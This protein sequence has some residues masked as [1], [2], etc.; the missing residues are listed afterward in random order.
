MDRKNNRHTPKIPLIVGLTLLFT[1]VFCF[2][3]FE[4]D[5]IYD[6]DITGFD[7]VSNELKR[8]ISVEEVIR[9]VEQ[10][11][12]GEEEENA[13]VPGSITA[14]VGGPST[15]GTTQPPSSGGSQTTPT[16]PGNQQPSNPGS[17]QPSN[18]Q[19]TQPTQPQPQPNPPQPAPSPTPG[20]AED[21]I[22][23]GLYTRED[24][25]YLVA[26]A[27]EDR[28]YEGFYA[29]ACCVR[30]RCQQLGKTVKEV[31]TAP[32]QFTGYNTADI[33]NYSNKDVYNAAIEV[34]RGGKSTVKDYM[35][36]FGRS[37]GYDIWYEANKCG[38]NVP[39]V[40]GTG[41]C[42]NV[43]YKNSGD[44]HNHVANKTSDAV[45]LYKDGVGWIN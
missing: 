24:L 2:L 5:S 34:L 33:G 8:P 1:L 10:L 36:Y 23:K 15:P 40:V 30:N 19:P 14:T 39:I 11:T 42:R 43:F 37:N 32:G 18:P 29:V 12:G 45:T 31:I 28:T 6:I 44:V 3:L 9:Q 22:A 13:Q 41:P 27:G 16:N 21:D 17:Q 35:F 38:S 26:L 25:D 20:T 4:T 7:T